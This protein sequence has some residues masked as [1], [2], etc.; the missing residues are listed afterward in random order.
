MIACHCFG[1]NSDT[2][3]SEVRLGATTLEVVG[4]RCGATTDCG[5]CADAVLDLVED[6]L[7]RSETASPIG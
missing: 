2:I 5:G 3:R 4:R 1:I 7:E 6:E